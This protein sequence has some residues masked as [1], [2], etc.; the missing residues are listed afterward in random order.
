VFDRCI[1]ARPSYELL[2]Q[3]LLDLKDFAATLDDSD[4]AQTVRERIEG[5]VD[6]ALE[7]LGRRD[8][9]PNTCIS[10]RASVV[11]SVWRRAHELDR[12]GWL[13]ADYGRAVKRL[14]AVRVV[15]A[16]NANAGSRAMAGRIDTYMTP[17]G[18]QKTQTTSIDPRHLLNEALRIHYDQLDTFYESLA[19]RQTTGAWF[20]LLGAA[21][22]VVAAVMLHHEQLLVFGALGGFISRAARLLRRRPSALHYGVSAVV[23]LLPP[24]VGALSG[25]AG[26][27][28]VQGLAELNVLSGD[29]FGRVW[30]HASRTSSLTLAFAFGFVERLIDRVVASASSTLG[31]PP[32]S[33][34]NSLSMGEAEALR[35]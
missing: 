14:R 5:G 33:V 21:L 7:A 13:M 4:P 3:T 20:T 32:P 1:S 17:K 9:M 11:L 28:I 27:A 23:F 10:L 22:V 25:W 35:D 15:L 18:T 19:S 26:T 30:D 16:G 6:E 34:S 31:H 2:V 8:G 24:V 12:L 29:T